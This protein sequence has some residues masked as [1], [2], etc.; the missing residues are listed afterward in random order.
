[1]STPNRW[2]ILPQ[3]GGFISGK[4]FCYD[5]SHFHQFSPLMLKKEVKDSGLKVIKVKSRPLGVPALQKISRNLKESMHAYLFGARLYVMATNYHPLKNYQ[6][7]P[8]L[9]PN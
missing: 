5:P 2:A 6:S 3:I 4:G 7:L 8:N 9:K 1:M